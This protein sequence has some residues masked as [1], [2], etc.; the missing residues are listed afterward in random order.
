MRCFNVQIFLYS[1]IMIAIQKWNHAHEL[2][3]HQVNRHYPFIRWI[4]TMINPIHSKINIF[5]HRLHWLQLNCHHQHEQLKRR[6]ICL[7]RSMDILFHFKRNWFFFPH[8]YLIIQQICK[9]PPEKLNRFAHGWTRITFTLKDI[10]NDALLSSTELWLREL[11]S[12]ALQHARDE[13]ILST[14][15]SPTFICLYKK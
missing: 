5:S 4:K 2:Y 10:S 9:I 12:R 8:L 1:S 15:I 14:R 6:S 3:P 13:L 11:K 7:V